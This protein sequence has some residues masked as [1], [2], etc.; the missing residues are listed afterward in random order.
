MRERHGWFCRRRRPVPRDQSCS[1]VRV[2]PI[3]IRTQIGGE[4]IGAS[5]NPANV[6]G[7]PPPSQPRQCRPH[8]AHLGFGA[9][10]LVATD[11]RAVVRLVT[12][13]AGEAARVCE[14]WAFRFSP[15]GRMRR[16]RRTVALP[17]RRGTSRRGWWPPCLGRQGPERTAR[18]IPRHRKAYRQPIP[19]SC[20]APDHGASFT[21]AARGGRQSDPQAQ[22]PSSWPRDGS[23]AAAAHTR[24]SRL[25]RLFSPPW[26]ASSP[27]PGPF[28]ADAVFPRD[29]LAA[30][31]SRPGSRPIKRGHRYGQ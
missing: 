15:P 18:P 14:Y 4:T 13:H 30:L 23:R 16:R 3:R 19:A 12:S 17:I 7:C 26:A 22:H 29:G 11:S 20:H 31:P 2:H 8:Q 28:C 24:A 9:R 5:A 10:G 21:V 1:N 25:C 27:V 6:H